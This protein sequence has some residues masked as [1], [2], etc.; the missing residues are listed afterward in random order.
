MEKG[1]GDV[2]FATQ[3]GTAPMLLGSAVSLCLHLGMQTQDIGV[4]EVSHSLISQ[5]VKSP[6]GFAPGGREPHSPSA[7]LLLCAPLTSALGQRNCP[8]K[9]LKL[10]AKNPEA[11][12]HATVLEPCV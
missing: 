10:A 12:P 3:M 5:G 11:N 6:E 9:V 1:Q 8:F 7:L 2:I 4:P